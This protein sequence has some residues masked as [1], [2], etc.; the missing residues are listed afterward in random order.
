MKNDSN[1]GNL[2]LSVCLSFRAA[3][4]SIHHQVDGGYT[5]NMKVDRPLFTVLSGTY[6]MMIDLDT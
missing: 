2:R 5:K 4:Q 3:V 6:L 1:G